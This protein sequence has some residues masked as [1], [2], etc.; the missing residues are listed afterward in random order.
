MAAYARRPDRT[1]S[2]VGKASPLCASSR[3]RAGPHATR[4]A[5]DRPSGEIVVADAEA[6]SRAATVQPPLPVS[7]AQREHSIPQRNGLA[8]FKNGVE[9]FNGS[10]QGNSCCNS[11]SRRR[12]TSKAPPLTA[13]ETKSYS[14]RPGSVNERAS[15]R[16]TRSVDPAV[17]ISSAERCDLNSKDPGTRASE[18]KPSPKQSCSTSIPSDGAGCPRSLVV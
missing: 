11:R 5:F 13:Q 14:R 1:G 7:L 12:T 15:A 2:V 9:C 3:G 16:Q 8:G 10:S 4:V 17:S 6:S 18:A